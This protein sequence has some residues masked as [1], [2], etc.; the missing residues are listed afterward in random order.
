MTSTEF[1]GFPEQTLVFLRGLSENNTKSWFDAHRDDYER[2]WLEPAKAFVVVAGQALARFAPDIRA[3]PKINGSIFRINRD[4]R[5]SADK[6]PY[7]DHL[8][9]WFW[10]GER[11]AAVS[12][13]FMRVTSDALAVGVGAHMFDRDRLAA[14]RALV[15]DPGAG[16]ELMKTVRAL[17]RKGLDVRGERYRQLPRGFTA[18]NALQERL[19]KHDALWIGDEEPLPAELHGPALVTS[20]AARWRRMAPLHRWLVDRLG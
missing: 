4:T 7:K 12:G 19:L 3:E 10:E 9:L 6:T 2:Y 17:E 11:K 5:F 14:Y 16:A 15:V 13:F 20:V 1:R 18:A 8:D